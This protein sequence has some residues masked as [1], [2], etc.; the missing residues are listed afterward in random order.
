MN[1]DT[2]LV[3]K[4]SYENEIVTNRRISILVLIT[5]IIFLLLAFLD[6]LKLYELGVPLCRLL[7]FLAGIT[8][9]AAY[10]TAVVLRKKN[11]W[12]K[13]I[14]F[15]LLNALLITNGIL[16]F[17]YPLNAD[18][19]TY[20]PIIISAAYYNKKFIRRN[21]LASWLLYGMLL[22]AN[23]YLEA[24]NAMIQNHHAFLEITLYRYPM[25]VFKSHFI[26]HTIFFILTADVCDA[27]SR[28]GWQFVKKQAENSNEIYSMEKEFSAASEMQVS[29]L[30]ENNFFTSDYNVRIKAFMRP[31]KAVG[32]DFYDYFMC[33][34]NLVFLIADVSDKGLPAALFMMKAKNA[35][36]AAFETGR[37]FDEAI[38]IANRL[39]C[40][41]NSKN[42]FM[43]SWIASVNTKS[44][45]GKYVNCGHLPP[46][47]RH[48][49]GSVTQINNE[50]DLMLGVFDNAEFKSH[51][52]RLNAND[53]LVLYTD[54]LTDAVNQ[55]GERFGE[56]RLKEI[57]LN[58][59]VNEE[60]KSDLL[61]NKVDDFAK[62]AVQFDDMT[63]IRVHLLNSETIGSEK[64]VLPAVT[65]SNETAID[66]VNALLEKSSCPQTVRQ[67][68]DVVIDEVCQNINDYAYEDCSDSTAK[69]ICF[70]AEVTENSI[71]LTFADGGKQFNP[72]KQENNSD[73]A[74]ED[75]LSVNGRGIFLYT[76]LMDKAEYAYIQQKNILKLTKIWNI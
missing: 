14:K 69:E 52:L 59:S 41:D 39:L 2:P 57:V 43:T 34:G 56:Q 26:P 60:E 25:E 30:P 27:I 50:P 29:S 13:V 6:Y 65:S 62:D 15:I 1:N 21:A 76:N 40:D 55:N 28:R 7:V 36:R 35:V 63:S 75:V 51:I 70:N 53:T 47:V 5:G 20:G 31:A 37:D 46:F 71:E 33:R 44:G 12:M 18:F 23:C 67:N 66:K 19:I 3:E 4:L 8:D 42:M 48:D 9:V 54:G 32:G 72:I 49:D 10:V 22:F 16:Y 45:T 73:S 64:M 74:E 24:T 58:L 61:I 11:K 17:L 38:R 68:I